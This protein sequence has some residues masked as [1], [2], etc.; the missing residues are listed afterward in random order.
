MP[1]SQLGSSGHLAIHMCVHHMHASSYTYTHT[2]TLKHTGSWILQAGQ[3]GPEHRLIRRGDAPAAQCVIDA[4]VQ[5]TQH[6]LA[7][8]HS[9]GPLSAPQSAGAGG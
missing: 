6:R 4:L 9:V 1:T 8:P 2:H 3:A 5:C 7:V